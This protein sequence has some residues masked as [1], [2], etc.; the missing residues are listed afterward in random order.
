MNFKSMFKNKMLKNLIIFGTLAN[1]TIIF[2]SAA[3]EADVPDFYLDT[4]PALFSKEVDKCE[5]VLEDVYARIRSLIASRAR[6][7]NCFWHHLISV[8]S[9]FSM[10]DKLAHKHILCAQCFDI[11]T[12]FPKYFIRNGEADTNAKLVSKRSS[13]CCV[14]TGDCSKKQAVRK[15]L[16]QL[17]ALN[18]VLE[19][20]SALLDNNAMIY[21]KF[22]PSGTSK[23]GCRIDVL[24]KFNVRGYHFSL[25]QTPKR[26]FDLGTLRVPSLRM[27]GIR[28]KLTFDNSKQKNYPSMAHANQALDKFLC[29]RSN[30]DLNAL[31][32]IVNKYVVM[33]CSTCYPLLHTLT[34]R[35]K[36]RFSGENNVF[37]GALFRILC[38]TLYAKSAV[39][40]KSSIVVCRASNI[41]QQEQVIT[42]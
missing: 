3:F 22:E 35:K 24:S 15:K 32:S 34:K 9:V 27:L 4:L 30:K 33:G 5:F 38:F 39:V 10:V 8:N 6:M 17:S 28:I 40:P 26:P 41:I 23:M 11:K 18:I 31:V 19:S 2:E 13:F 25:P 14:I 36:E 42:G 7:C 29:T 16:R 20:I 37:T 21:V 12:E 1:A